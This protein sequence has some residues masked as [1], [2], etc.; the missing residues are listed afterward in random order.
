[1]YGIVKKS[2]VKLDN[3]KMFPFRALPD[4]YSFIV[5]LHFELIVPNMVMP[6]QACMTSK[7]RGTR[8]FKMEVTQ[9]EYIIIL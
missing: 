5:N 4:H 1:M 9:N 6:L 7:E 8:G 3:H 2:N